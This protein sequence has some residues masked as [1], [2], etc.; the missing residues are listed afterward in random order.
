M[1]LG[2]LGAAALAAQ[3][4]PQQSPPVAD[5]NPDLRCM[6]AFSIVL[7]QTEKN[8]DMK[9]GDTKEAEKA[10]L[11]T[12]VMYYVGKIDG[13]LPGFN[14]A[15]A[16]KKLVEAPGYGTKLPADLQRCGAEAAKRGQT[17]IELGEELQSMAPLVESKHG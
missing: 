10:G 15:G 9:N 12:I 3:Q 8:G 6:V 17:L 11:T 4:S 13:R 1:L 5:D 2:L 14:Y 7:G 16:V